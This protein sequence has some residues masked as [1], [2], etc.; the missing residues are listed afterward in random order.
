VWPPSPTEEPPTV[1]H[2]LP[3]GPAAPPLIL[4]PPRDH[5]REEFDETTASA[6]R[7]VD[8]WFRRL[9]ARRP[10]RGVQCA[11]LNRDAGLRSDQDQASPAAGTGEDIRAEDFF[12]V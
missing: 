9:R 8:G 7:S 1:L 3:G 12:H 6:P 4:A 2:W 11:S 5:R 10:A